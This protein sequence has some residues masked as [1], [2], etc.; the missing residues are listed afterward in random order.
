MS[1]EPNV[2]SW[3]ITTNL[4]VA[5]ITFQGWIGP[6]DFNFEADD[7]GGAP[8]W[9]N[10]ELVAEDDGLRS[11]DLINACPFGPYALVED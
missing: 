3:E 11:A 8:T 6:R 7:L 5:N 10:I 4:G 1:S 2:A 9:V